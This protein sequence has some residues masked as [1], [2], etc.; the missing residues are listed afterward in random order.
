MVVSSCGR[1]HR[2]RFHH[3]TLPRWSSALAPHRGVRV[4]TFVVGAYEIDFAES[5]N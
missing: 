3:R 1:V 2:R 5:G 4:F